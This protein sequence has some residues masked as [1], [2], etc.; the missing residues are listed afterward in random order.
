MPKIYDEEVITIRIKYG[1]KTQY[2]AA[3]PL[4]KEML[5][6]FQLH[7]GQGHKGN[8]CEVEMEDEKKVIG[9]K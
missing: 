1:S 9:E 3:S 6:A 4:I 7:F 5:T 2:E 8:E